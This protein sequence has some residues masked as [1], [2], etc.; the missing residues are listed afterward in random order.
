MKLNKLVTILALSGIILWMPSCNGIPIAPTSSSGVEKATVKVQTDLQGH[1]TEQNNIMER[2]KR[3]NTP[4]AVKYLYLI[5]PFTGSVILSSTVQGKVTSSGKRLTPTSI[6]EEW[7]GVETNTDA[8]HWGGDPVQVNGR[9]VLTNELIQDDGTYGSSIE[10]LYWIDVRG[11]YHQEYAHGLDVHISDQP[12][13]F[14][15]VSLDLDVLESKADT[16]K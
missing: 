8:L 10:Y 16:S 1:T 4:G 6:N 7:N 5:S 11:V 15:G 14:K 3:D 9:T 2:Y 12:I 13:H